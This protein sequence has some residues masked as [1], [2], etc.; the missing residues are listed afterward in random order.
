MFLLRVL[1]AKGFKYPN[2]SHMSCDLDFCQ[3][4]IPEATLWLI[5]GAGGTFR[6]E[7][8]EAGSEV[9]QRNSAP[10][11]HLPPVT[12]PFHVVSSAW[13]LGVNSQ[14]VV[15]VSDKFLTISLHNCWGTQLGIMMSCI[16]MK[17]NKEGAGCFVP[18]S[19][20]ILK[21]ERWLFLLHSHNGNQANKPQAW[22]PEKNSLYWNTL[23][24]EKAQNF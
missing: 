22:S 9:F 2:Q 16:K 8:D 13:N 23:F 12:R 4:G 10:W 6:E 20:P 11:K 1:L 17:K 15:L 14:S 3:K 21:Q 18:Y 7:G 19:W 24:F 5:A